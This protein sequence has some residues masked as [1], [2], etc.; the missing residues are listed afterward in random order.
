M[1][2][3]WLA[4]R[5]CF[6][7]CMTAAFLAATGA[8]SLSESSLFYVLA[9][10]VLRSWCYWSRLKLRGELTGLF[11]CSL[12][13]NYQAERGLVIVWWP[14]E[15]GANLH[16][17]QVYT[18]VDFEQ[19]LI[20]TIHY[21]SMLILPQVPVPHGMVLDNIKKLDSILWTFKMEGIHFFT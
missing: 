21:C 10:K 7:L 5:V 14:L 18:M 4:V 15:V 2:R 20:Q 11:K 17:C 8:T 9:F 1:Q 6:Y 12:H 13:L 19:K 16:W 3:Q